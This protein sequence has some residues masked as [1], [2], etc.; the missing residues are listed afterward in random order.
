M[1]LIALLSFLGLFIAKTDE[2]LFAQIE[3]MCRT[4]YVNTHAT[5]AENVYR[6]NHVVSVVLILP[7]VILDALRLILMEFSQPNR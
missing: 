3:I 2:T 5:G 4:C 1:A 6:H 7:R